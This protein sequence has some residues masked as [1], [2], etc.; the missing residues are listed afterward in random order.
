[1][2]DWPALARALTGEEV[3]V[4]AEN[5]FDGVVLSSFSSETHAGQQ[6]EGLI[7]GPMPEGDDT[8]QTNVWIPFSSITSLEVY[9]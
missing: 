2:I 1:M 9:P 3:V 8:V 5:R 6:Y 4:W 7:I